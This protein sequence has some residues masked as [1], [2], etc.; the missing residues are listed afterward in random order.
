MLIKQNIQRSLQERNSY[1]KSQR[2]T[3]LNPIDGSYPCIKTPLALTKAMDKY[4][5]LQ[6]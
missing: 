3:H 4:L 5:G 2:I 1:L 6:A